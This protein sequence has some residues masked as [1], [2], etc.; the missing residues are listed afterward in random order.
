MLDQMVGGEGYIECSNASGA[1]RTT[2]IL[3]R[4]ETPQKRRGVAQSYVA[5]NPAEFKLHLIR[6]SGAFVDRD[7]APILRGVI[8]GYILLLVLRS[9]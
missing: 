5:E 1:S 9:P 6:T 3:E 8:V 4:S 7:A 2:L